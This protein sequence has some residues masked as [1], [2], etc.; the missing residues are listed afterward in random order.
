MNPIV[1]KL[2][3]IQVFWYG[4][5]VAAAIGISY[6]FARRNIRAD[7]MDP[8]K[9]DGL[10]LKLIVVIIVGARLA[11][12]VSEWGFFSSQ[13]LGD[14]PDRSW[15]DGIPWSHYRRSCFWILLD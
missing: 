11:Y 13:P 2:G 9:T 5:L 12:V 10:F 14:Y 7:G 1:F 4:V 15:R 3:P 8:D 6:W